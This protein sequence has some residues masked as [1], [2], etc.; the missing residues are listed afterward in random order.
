MCDT[1]TIHSQNIVCIMM[2]YI[3]INF[4]FLGNNVKERNYIFSLIIASITRLVKRP[5]EVLELITGDRVLPKT[6]KIVP[7]ASLLCNQH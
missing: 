5:Q 2:N 4:L 3:T 7:V 6:Y 1:K